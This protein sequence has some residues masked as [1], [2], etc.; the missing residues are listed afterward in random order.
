MSE[1]KELVIKKILCNGFQVPYRQDTI[2][3][4][5]KENKAIRL[6]Y[7]K[8]YNQIKDNTIKY[9][10]KSRNKDKYKTAKVESLKFPDE[11]FDKIISIISKNNNDEINKSQELPSIKTKYSQIHYKPYSKLLYKKRIP[12]INLSERIQRIALEKRQYSDKITEFER[13]LLNAS[14][15]NKKL[16]FPSINK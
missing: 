9:T 15:H 16:S 6:N 14:L 8:I 1:A 13:L 3:V 2:I 10:R 5:K 7:T 12:G 11:T 4:E